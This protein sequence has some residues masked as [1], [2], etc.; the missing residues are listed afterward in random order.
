MRSRLGSRQPA[1]GASRPASRSTMP[2]LRRLFCNPRATAGAFKPAPPVAGPPTRPP[3]APIEIDVHH[4]RLRLG[5]SP[6]EGSMTDPFEDHCWKDLVT[7]D[8]LEVYSAYRRKVFVGGNP[9]LLAID[10]YELVYRGGARPP[11]ELARTYP[12]S[13]GEYAYA[14]IDPTRQ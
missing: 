1:C 5:F 4:L 9:A 6:Q 11:A 14:A 12:S 2:S 13:C 8:L 10:L 3:A 7:P